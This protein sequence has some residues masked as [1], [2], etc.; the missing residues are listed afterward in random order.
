VEMETWGAQREKNQA[1]V[2]E[3]NKVNENM[4]VLGHRGEKKGPNRES[5]AEKVMTSTKRTYRKGR[6]G[7]KSKVYGLLCKKGFQI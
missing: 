7:E 2:G 4:I 6:L 3:P 1:V 5:Q